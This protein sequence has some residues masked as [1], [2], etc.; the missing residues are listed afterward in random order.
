M[1]NHAIHFNNLTSNFACYAKP[2]S[3]GK[4][5]QTFSRFIVNITCI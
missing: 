5:S 3:F 2:V 4:Y 1:D